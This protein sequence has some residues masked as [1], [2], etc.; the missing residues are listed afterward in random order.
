[1]AFF[2]KL[3]VIISLSTIV[4]AT[5]L[6]STKTLAS[7]LESFDG[8]GPNNKCWE[9]ML[10]LQHCTGDIVTF[11]LNG[12]THLGSGCCN[13]LLT[14]AQ[15]CWGNLLTSLGLTTEEAEILRGFCSRVA[16]VNNSLLPSIT[17][18]APAPAPAPINDY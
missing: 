5:S 18:D 3:F 15:E 11:F 1:M 8:S 2:L 13:A 14:I 6:S 17:V 9:T 12:Q 16:S 7:R 4:T 10:E